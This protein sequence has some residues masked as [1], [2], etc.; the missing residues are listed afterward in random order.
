MQGSRCRA[1]RPGG[2]VPTGDREPFG[3]KSPVSSHPWM[4]GVAYGGWCRTVTRIACRTA[5]ERTSSMAGEAKPGG[6]GSPPRAG[7][8]WRV[9]RVTLSRL[10]IEGLVACYHDSARLMPRNVYQRLR[11][12]NFV[13]DASNV[14]P[15]GKH[16]LDEWRRQLPD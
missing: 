7:W 3:R 13:D 5:C 2:P 10:E 14:T 8:K 16:W 1:L 4:T 15:A 6:N 11:S 12:L 9:D